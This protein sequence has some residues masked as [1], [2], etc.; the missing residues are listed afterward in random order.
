MIADIQEGYV[1]VTVL[2]GPGSSPEGAA[3]E[4]L[5]AGVVDDTKELNLSLFHV[6]SL[7]KL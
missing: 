5:P 6:D 3:V 7:S 2:G 4:I 1:G